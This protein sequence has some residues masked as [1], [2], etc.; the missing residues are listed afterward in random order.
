M[1]ATAKPLLNVFSDS[2][3]IREWTRRFFDMA[4]GSGVVA[5]QLTRG[6]RAMAIGK[7]VEVRRVSNK[8]P[9]S[10]EGTTALVH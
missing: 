2:S 10:Y 9:L 3:S 8:K 1:A 6:G 4:I 7:I 5:N